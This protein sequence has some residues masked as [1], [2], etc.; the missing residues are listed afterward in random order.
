MPPRQ[1]PPSPQDRLSK[2]DS[3][4]IARLFQNMGFKSFQSEERVHVWTQDGYLLCVL[5]WDGKV[6]GW[7]MQLAQPLLHTQEDLTTAVAV[8]QAQEI[9]LKTVAA[10][11]AKYK[12]RKTTANWL[13]YQGHM[14][15]HFLS[16]LMPRD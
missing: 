5:Q 4:G 13:S 14:A 8:I 16:S 2:K 11:W 3:T 12:G 1:K 15:A 7:Q 6:G 10:A 9:T